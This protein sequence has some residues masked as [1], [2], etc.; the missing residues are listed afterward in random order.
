MIF[1]KT[2]FTQSAYRE[3]AGRTWCVLSMWWNIYS[4]IQCYASDC[5]ELIQNSKV[6]SLTIRLNKWF[7]ARWDQNLFS[8]KNDIYNC[9]R[10]LRN[11]KM[12]P[13]YF[14]Y[15]TARL[16]TII[17][18]AQI[19]W[20]SWQSGS[21]SILNESILRSLEDHGP[22]IKVNTLPSRTR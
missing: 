19:K 17:A 3:S 18:T 4:K 22:Y 16:P 20:Y 12:I 10:M 7:E 8:P 5:S 11:K 15:C 13:S 9:G 6:W 1:T 2:M 21:H 14:I